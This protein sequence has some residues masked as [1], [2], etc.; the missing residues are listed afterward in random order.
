MERLDLA[1]QS[2]MKITK[3][4][5]F[6][7]HVPVTGA[8]IEDSTHQVTH[9]GAPGVMI[10]TDS[11]LSGYGYTGTHAHLPTDRLI[12]DCIS[13]TYAPLLD[14][15]DP[16]DV[17]RLWKKLFH[18]PPAQW[19]GRKG[20]T[21]L[22]L[23]AVDIALWDLKAKAAGLPLWKL[24]GGSEKKK[25]EAYNT[26]A[27]WL[28]RPIEQLVDGIRRVIEQEGFKGV[29]I[30]VGSGDPCRDLE[31]L[32]AVRKVI[33]DG[34]KLMA[35][36]NGRWD[37]PSALSI[38]RKFSEFDVYWL[39]EPLWYDDIRGH[40]ALARSIQTPIALGEQLYNVDDFKNFIEAGAM[41][42]VQADAMRL[43]GITEW[44]QVADLA[45][46]YRLPVAP[47]IG[48]MM[49]VHLHL[50]LAHNA[51]TV[52]EYIPWLRECFEDPATVKNGEFLIPH[53]PG[54]G[55]TL[56]PSALERY[57]VLK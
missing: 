57:N 39:E 43:G 56:Q 13:A 23:S 6:I 45:F 28:D 49:Q 26:D 7:L 48:D 40:A 14:G 21:H 30:K 22:A 46:A 19:V 32:E 25:L 41:H 15:E 24:L 27:G 2:D 50:S 51:C 44:W 20:I 3:V 11:G 4:E 34:I 17:Q 42:F 52:L 1:A 10:S 47:H 37:L 55:T 38:A 5:T 54:A 53:L 16:H 33:G 31:R 35:D 18:F 8:K 9:W 12:T 36:A 29:K